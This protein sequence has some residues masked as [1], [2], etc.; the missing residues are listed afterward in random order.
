VHE[1][2]SFQGSPADGGR[3]ERRVT[4][5][6]VVLLVAFVGIAIVKPWGS[7]AEPVPTAAIPGAS[8]IP[9][10]PSLPTAAPALPSPA[11]AAGL[12]ALPVAFTTP[13]PPA[14]ASW[15]GLDWRRLS[16]DDPLSLVASVLQWRRGYVAVGWLAAP[17]ATPVWTSADGARWDALPFDTSSTFWPGMNVIGVAHLGTGLVALTEMVQWC[18]EPCPLVYILPV[19]SWTSPNGRTW[20]PHVLPPEWL[21]TP[22]GQAPL[23]ATGP[24][25][26]VVASS[27]PVSRLAASTDGS[28]WHLLPA[29]AFPARFALDDLRGTAGGYV[30]LGRWMPAADGR[31]AASLWSRDGRSWSATPTILPTRPTAGSGVGSAGTSLVIARDGMI[32]VGRGAT[33]PGAALWW[34]SADGRVWRALPAFPPLGPAACTGGGCSSKPNGALV[35]DGQRMVAVRG[36]ADP[37]AWTSSDGLAWKRLRV[38]GDVPGELATQAVLLPGGV[39][40]TDGTT[41]WFGEAQVP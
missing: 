32:A 26:L 5:L 36:G 27:G 9:P 30:A 12:V 4:A 20:T 37:A 35:G 39:L 14:S 2:R 3:N 23:F 15:T 8:V 22:P 31:D 1:G 11:A 17:P 33:T 40:L 19:I 41:T 34:Q 13:A 10:P 7:P 18:G 38:T 21:A 25:G 29:G 6:M 16:R 28:H 24:A